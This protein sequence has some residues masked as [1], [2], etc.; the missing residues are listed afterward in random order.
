MP[1]STPNAFS[2]TPSPVELHENVSELHENVSVMSSSGIIHLYNLIIT[3]ISV[4][5]LLVIT[6]IELHIRL[7][8][9][10]IYTQLSR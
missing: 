9:G 4:V 6:H 5:V 7:R 8:S 3:S 10:P 1:L 2:H